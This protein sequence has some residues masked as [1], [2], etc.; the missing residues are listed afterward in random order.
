MVGKIFPACHKGAQNPKPEP[1]VPPY[2]GIQD[3]QNTLE[4]VLLALIEGTFGPQTGLQGF[5]GDQKKTKS[6]ISEP[7]RPQVRTSHA[8]R[9]KVHNSRELL[10]TRAKTSQILSKLGQ[11]TFHSATA[12]VSLTPPSPPLP[13][14]HTST[15]LY[16]RSCLNPSPRFSLSYLSVVREV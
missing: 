3:W 6:G 9:T 11:S 8:T 14:P 16:S 15:L 10:Q 4:A 2:A 5:V 12:P 7:K 13:P 1:P